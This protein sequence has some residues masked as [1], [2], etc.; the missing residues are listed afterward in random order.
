LWT[1]KSEAGRLRVV[2]VHGTWYRDRIGTPGLQPF[3]NST[4]YERGK[5]QMEGMTEALR[6]Q[7]VKVYEW[8]Q[9]FREILDGATLKE[10]AAIV[11]SV[12]G[13]MD[14]KPTPEELSWRHLSDGYPLHPYYDEGRDEVIWGPELSG[15]WAAPRD[16]SFNTQIGMV[17]ANMRQFKRQLAP[18]FSRLMYQWHPDFRENIEIAWDAHEHF[19]GR[20]K[21]LEYY[22]VRGAGAAIEGGDN[23]PIDEETILC[24]VGLRSNIWGFQTYLEEM[25]RADRDEQI[26]TICAVKLIDHAASRVTHL[27]TVINWP[28]RR[29]AIVLPYVLESELARPRLPERRLWVKLIEARRRYLER[30][31]QPID[32]ATVL[33]TKDLLHAGETEV[34]ARG[35]DGRPVLVKRERNLLDHL[36]KE[37]KLD[38]DGLIPV[39]G[40][41]EKENDVMNVI[42]TMQ[43][44]G[45]TGVNGLAIKPGTFLVWESNIHAVD[46]LEE[47]GVRLVKLQDANTVGGAGPHCYTCPLDRDGI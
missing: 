18:R 41:P 27:D 38:A 36:I 28:D 24:G 10:R 7:G 34:Y 23:Q 33:N 17:I 3:Q 12:W 2:G 47:A 16:D 5:E 22:G 46:A 1:V 30:H 42:V 43:Q 15:A 20:M 9:V 35:K 21:Y 13:D 6:S 37:D 31:H 40:W 19:R 11:E 45:R 39:G 44:Q 8:S 25:F 4:L 29:K 26:K 14:V 32:Q